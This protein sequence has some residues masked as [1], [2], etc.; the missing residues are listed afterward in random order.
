MDTSTITRVGTLTDSTV[1][2]QVN[3][4]DKDAFLKLLI[5]ELSNQ[6]PMNPMEDKDFIAQL[7]TFSSLE[8]MQKMNTANE[9]VSS[10]Q[11]ATQAISL[12][13][14]QVDFASTDSTSGV[15]GEVTSVV[16]VDG[17]PQLKVLVPPS[18]GATEPTTVEVDPS[19]VTSVY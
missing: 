3:N 12:I 7:A 10:S 13:G 19:N 14:R 15:S 16:F 18:E 9:K 6:D 1:T 17:A 11:A 2:R 4:L 8:Q 5:A